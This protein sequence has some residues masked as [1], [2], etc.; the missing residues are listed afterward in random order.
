MQ[1]PVPR[2]D[3]GTNPNARMAMVVADD[4]P[5]HYLFVDRRHWVVV[6][7]L[8]AGLVHETFFAMIPSPCLE[9]VG[10][11]GA[12]L[13]LG[14][15]VHGTASSTAGPAAEAEDPTLVPSHRCPTTEADH[16]LAVRSYSRMC[17]CDLDALIGGL[18]PRSG[19]ENLAAQVEDQD[20]VPRQWCP[21]AKADDSLVADSYCVVRACELDAM[22]GSLLHRVVV[23]L[24]SHQAPLPRFHRWKLWAQPFRDH[25]RHLAKSTAALGVPL[26]WS[27]PPRGQLVFP[28]DPQRSLE[29]VPATL[30]APAAPSQGQPYLPL[31]A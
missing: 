31:H 28:P 21:M 1:V 14:D 13:A 22:M 8:V 26:L 27:C 12:R 16:R 19:A 9:Q 23:H 20:P 17:T 30:Q 29:V 24:A 3:R 25:A 2:F 6:E 15:R 4:E 11:V 18:V 10:Q 7:S 5:R